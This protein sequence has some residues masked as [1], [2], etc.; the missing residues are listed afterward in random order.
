LLNDGT[1]ARFG[2]RDEVLAALQALAQ[3]AAAQAA[4]TPGLP[5]A[6][7]PQGAPA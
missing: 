4:G 1:V 2:T 3:Q 7:S 5:A 6:V